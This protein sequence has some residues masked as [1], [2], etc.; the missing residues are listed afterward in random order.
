MATLN[1]AIITKKIYDS[2]LEVFTTK[3]L[4]D[5]LGFPK[6]SSLFSWLE[7]LVKNRVLEK[8]ERG[9][10]ILT[11]A[12]VNAFK[13]AN[14]IYSP[15]YVSLES[16][17]NF[18]GILS[19]F[20]VEQTSVTVKK[21]KQKKF[22]DKIFSYAHIKKELFWGYEKQDGYLMAVPEKAILD[23]LYLES[24]GLKRSSIEE[25][26]LVEL[27]KKKLI[28]YSKNYQ[29]NDWVIKQVNKLLNRR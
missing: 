21:T 18:H 28:D 8:I 14:F 15:S 7:R 25:W 29:F 26:D 2:G 3:T 19:Q 9:K 6:K 1:L 10:F 16:A 24:K 27:N 11:E 12:E 20:P 4:E 13:L 22:K 23:Q 5:I 17:L